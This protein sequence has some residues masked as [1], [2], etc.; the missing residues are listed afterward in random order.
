MSSA[1]STISNLQQALNCAG[2][3]DCCDQL[4]TAI[5][6][7][8][9]RLDG[10]ERKQKECCEKNKDDD[11]SNNNDLEERIKKLEHDVLNLGGIIKDC[12]DDL[13]D[14]LDTTTEHTEAHNSAQEIFSAI[15]DIFLGE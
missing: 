14:I 1:S 5:N 6:Q 7:L 3:C 12:V 2:K 9:N 11:K 8:N 13:S 4:Q 15:I 10:L